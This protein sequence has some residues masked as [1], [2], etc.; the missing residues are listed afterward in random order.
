MT[1]GHV[2]GGAVR[3]MNALHF[4]EQ[5]SVALVHDH[6]AILSADEEA[7]MRGIGNDIV[8]TSFATD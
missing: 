8:P 5:A 1:G 6:H 2:D 7:V 4:T 3:A